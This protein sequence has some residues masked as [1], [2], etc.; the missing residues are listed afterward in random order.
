MRVRQAAGVLPPVLALAVFV[1]AGV[2]IGG[3]PLQDAFVGV[4]STAALQSAIRKERL[5]AARNGANFVQLTPDEMASILHARLDPVAQQALD[6]L[7]LTLG[8]DRVTLDGQLLMETVGRELLGA[9]AGYVQGRQPIRVTGP[10]AV[11]DTGIVSWTPDEVTVMALRLPQAAIPRL[12][13]YLTGGTEGSF[14]LRVPRT[15]GDVKVSR[16]KVTF[17]RWGG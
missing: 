7:R 15:V 4:P 14:F 1:V 2:G 16:G 6:S 17:Y 9:M 10:V 5:I 13:N 11:R 3:G 8:D 12:V